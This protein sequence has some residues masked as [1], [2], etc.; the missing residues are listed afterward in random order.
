VNEGSHYLQVSE[1][2]HYLQVNEGSHYLQVNEGS[3]YRGVIA[4]DH[5]LFREALR[6]ALVGLFDR[7]DIA[8]TGTLKELVDLF[9]RSDDVDLVLLDLQGIRG[10]SG[11][12]D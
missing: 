2:L 10:F 5:P 8:E 9:D 4:D 3:H 6:E 7:D 1:G 12:L 11:L